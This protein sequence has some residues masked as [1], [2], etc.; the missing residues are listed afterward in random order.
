MKR[1]DFLNKIGFPADLEAEAEQLDAEAQSLWDTIRFDY[2]TKA[3]KERKQQ[4]DPWSDKAK[5]RNRS[6][7]LRKQASD[8]RRTAARLRRV[9]NDPW[10]HVR[11]EELREYGFEAEALVVDADRTAVPIS[12]ATWLRTKAEISRRRLYC[13]SRRM[14]DDRT[15][16]VS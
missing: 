1:E 3:G 12:A 14:G 2:F 7:E 15:T 9:H 13:L 11:S 6:H 4:P 16:S 10:S 5:T 8:L